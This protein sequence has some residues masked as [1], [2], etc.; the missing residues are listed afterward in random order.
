[1]TDTKRPEGLRGWL[2]LVGFYLI[3]STIGFGYL[4]YLTDHSGGWL[5]IMATLM[6]FG[7]ATLV[8]EFFRKRKDLIDAFSIVVGLR[9]AII[10][11]M[12]VVV[13]AETDGELV[14]TG[15]SA[16]YH[17]LFITYVVKSKRVRNTFIK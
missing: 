7:F 12:A 15:V 3:E 4:W 16:L 5:R 6:F 11:L 14:K 9:I 8:Y 17:A 2:I 10:A 13:P 1:M